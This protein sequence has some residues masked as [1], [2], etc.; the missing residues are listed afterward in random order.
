[1]I[2]HKS[3]LVG[4]FDTTYEGYLSL[5][6]FYQNCKKHQN[7]R[8]EIDL[9]LLNWIDANLCGLWL[10]MIRD[11]KAENNLDFNIA[12]LYYADKFKNEAK[13]NILLRNGFIVA[14]RGMDEILEEDWDDRKSTIGV[15]F[16]SVDECDNFVNYFESQFLNHRGCNLLENDKEDLYMAYCELF[17]NYEIHAHTQN[18][19][20]VCG[21]FYPQKK[22]L[23]FSMTDLG[24][25]FL[26]NISMFTQGVIN[27]P[28]TSVE[29]ALKKGNSTKTDAKGGSGLSTID[30]FCRQKNGNLHIITNGVYTEYNYQKNQRT[31]NYLPEIFKGTTVHLIFPTN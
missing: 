2:H 11:L 10:A 24:V 25:G 3:A 22:Q 12:S 13:F 14:L 6:R 26:D 4:R 30:E 20:Y 15:R 16:F 18:P 27:D 1:M 23:V 8:I 9:S 28:I 29:W 31:Y 7:C 21:Q 17:A 19:V 5:T